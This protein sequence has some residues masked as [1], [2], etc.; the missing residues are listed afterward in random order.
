MELISLK[1]VKM[2]EEQLKKLVEIE[3]KTKNLRGYL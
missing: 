1:G 3:E 2:F